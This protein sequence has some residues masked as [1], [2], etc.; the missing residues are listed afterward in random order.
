M[1]DQEVGE[2]QVSMV[3]NMAKV[4]KVCSMHTTCKQTTHILL[5]YTSVDHRL[6]EL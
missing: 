1:V 2:V 6:S 3:C 5:E 4:G